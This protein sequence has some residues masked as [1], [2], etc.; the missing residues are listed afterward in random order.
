MFDEFAWAVGLFE[1]EGSIICKRPARQKSTVRCLTMC[2]TDEDTVRRFHK[3]VAGIGTVR[4]Y[5]RPDCK[6]LWVW[7]AGAWEDIEP[8]AIRFYPHLSERRQRAI[9]RLL[10]NPPSRHLRAGRYVSR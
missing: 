7:K 2:S 6:R 5:D 3:A 9:V 1:G 10:F 8:L 4:P